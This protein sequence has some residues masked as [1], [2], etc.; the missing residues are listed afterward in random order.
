M[1]SDWLLFGKRFDLA[2]EGAE[3]VHRLMK[4]F[5]RSSAS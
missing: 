4:G 2:K 1:C 3:A 5:Q